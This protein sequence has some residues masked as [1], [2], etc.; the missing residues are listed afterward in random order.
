MR[1][2]RPGIDEMRAGIDRMRGTIDRMR[3]GIGEM[4]P[5][6]G[7]YNSEARLP[8]RACNA[9]DETR[10]RGRNLLPGLRKTPEPG[11]TQLTKEFG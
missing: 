1:E 8:F 7:D 11:K 6:I 5:G 10:G 3:A 2:M 4:T 9:G